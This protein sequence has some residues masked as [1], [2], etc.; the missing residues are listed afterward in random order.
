MLPNSFLLDY[1]MLTAVLINLTLLALL[2]AFLGKISQT[3]VVK[4]GLMTLVIG[5][6]VVVLLYFTGF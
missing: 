3:S 5:V 1:A 2:G 6:G 4:Y